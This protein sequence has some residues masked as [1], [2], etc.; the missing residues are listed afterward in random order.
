MESKLKIFTKNDCPKCPQAKQLGEDMQKEGKIK[1]E[2][3]NVDEADGL[4][5]AQLYSVM[6][7]PSIILCKNDTEEEEIKSWRGEVPS[8]A[9][10]IYRE[11]K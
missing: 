2:S 5:E 4:A 10:D 9:E 11:L 3:Y 6:A 7:T 1:V 8:S